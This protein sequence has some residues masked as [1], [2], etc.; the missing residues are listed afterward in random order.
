V[1]HWSYPVG[2]DHAIVEQLLL[3]AKLRLVGKHIALGNLTNW[4]TLAK[5]GTSSTFKGARIWSTAFFNEACLFSKEAVEDT[6]ATMATLIE[7]VTTNQLLNR[8]IW[9][10]INTIFLLHT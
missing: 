1:A 10:L 7:V 2:V 5:G 3:D 6:P 4:L 8:K 9:Y